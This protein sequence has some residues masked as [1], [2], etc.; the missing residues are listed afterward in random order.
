MKLK[1][2]ETGSF[3]PQPGAYSGV[4]T[5]KHFCIGSVVGN[6]W[7]SARKG[8]QDTF[9]WKITQLFYFFIDLAI[10]V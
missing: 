4:C 10:D 6:I 3:R 5:G 2:Q 9:N 1:D 8:Q 7:K